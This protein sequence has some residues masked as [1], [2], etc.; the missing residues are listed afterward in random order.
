MAEGLLKALA[1]DRYD[2]YSGGTEPGIVRP[3]AISVLKELGI[4]ING[5]RSKSVTEFDDHLIEFVLTVCD[6]ARKNCPYFPAAKKV[7]HHAFSDPARTKGDEAVRIAE[8]RRVRDEIKNY[9]PEFLNE[10]EDC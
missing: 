8:F 6:D 2:V 10:I 5:N 1:G 3:E 7:V 4:D 9:L